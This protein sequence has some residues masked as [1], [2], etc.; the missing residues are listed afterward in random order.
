MLHALLLDSIKV[1]QNVIKIFDF[2]QFYVN[3]NKKQIHHL[4]IPG[5][6]MV[7]HTYKYFE[8]VIVLK[9]VKYYELIMASH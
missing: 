2:I 7:P 8:E 9:T 6:N 1:M 5:T 4:R 3:I